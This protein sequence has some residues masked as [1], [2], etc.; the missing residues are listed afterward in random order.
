MEDKMPRTYVVLMLSVVAL[1]FS[2]CTGD[3]R[4]N[5]A[6][7]YFDN[8]T[9]PHPQQWTQQLSPENWK[10]EDWVAHNDGDAMRLVQKFIN[11]GIITR[12]YVE[13]KVPVLDVGPRFYHLS[14]FDKARV[15]QTLDH[16]YKVTSKS[17][18]VIYLK[19][20]KT[21]YVIGTYTAT[22]L[23]LE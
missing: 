13:D 19:D 1:G 21:R 20:S 6:Q 3:S 17:P 11:S 10:P 22:G 8:G 14:G 12:S 2:A 4:E 23:H 9:D 5:F 18:G 15:V 16:I 7:P